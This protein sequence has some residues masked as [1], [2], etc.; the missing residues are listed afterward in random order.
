VNPWAKERRRHDI[1]ALCA[2]HGGGGHAQV[3]GVTLGPDELPRARATL[4]A[5]VKELTSS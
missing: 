3:G 5:I 1:G 2:R 4:E